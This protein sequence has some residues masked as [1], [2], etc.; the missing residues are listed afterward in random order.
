[1]ALD[2]N[3]SRH[4]RAGRQ[5]HTSGR[6]AQPC[7]L[8]CTPFGLTCPHAAAA[9]RP[10]VT[11]MVV[12]SPAASSSLTKPNTLFLLGRLNSLSSTGFL[13]KDIAHPTYKDMG[14]HIPLLHDVNIQGGWLLEASTRNSLKPSHHERAWPPAPR[15][16]GVT[17][18]STPL[19]GLPLCKLNS[20]AGGTHQGMTLMWLSRSCFRSRAA[21]SRACASWQHSHSR[22]CGKEGCQSRRPC[23]LC[24]PCLM[25]APFT[26]ITFFTP[27]TCSVLSL[28]SDMR[29]YSK[30]TRLPVIL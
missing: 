14:L 21:S 13:Q 23:P 16:S 18:K 22:A 29:V 9:S 4:P 8:T 26:C 25:P 27:L 7:K 15:C 2:M 20:S 17:K 11:R 24:P 6:V 30:V 10:R 19:F 28:T 5:A 1:M 12:G 3:G